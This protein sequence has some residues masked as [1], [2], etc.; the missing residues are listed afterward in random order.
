MV[1]SGA[2][3]Q[4]LYRF[5]IKVVVKNCRVRPHRQWVGISRQGHEKSTICS[6]AIQK[7]PFLRQTCKYIS[8]FISLIRWLIL[9]QTNLM[10]LVECYSLILLA[11]KFCGRTPMTYTSYIFGNPQPTIFGKPQPTTNSHLRFELKF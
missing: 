2:N 7:S 3:N 1:A 5:Y 4:P 6:K 10:C 8:C 11:L 9:L